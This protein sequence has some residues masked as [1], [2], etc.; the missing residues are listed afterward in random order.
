[1]VVILTKE[2]SLYQFW[3]GFGVQAFEE[4]SVPSGKDSPSFPYLTYQA[5]FDSFGGE[6]QLTASLWDRDREGYSALLRNSKKAEEISAN[7]GR[8]GI[9]LNCDNGAIWIKRGS[10]FAQN[11]GDETDNLIKR[12]YL[13]ITAEFLT[14][15]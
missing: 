8:G 12:K 7:I 6:V 11:M 1:M 13:N 15:D 3:S 14:V 10:P 5:S 4:N 9:I 2:Q